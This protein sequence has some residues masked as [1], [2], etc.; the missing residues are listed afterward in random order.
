MTKR[1]KKAILLLGA[2]AAIA[3]PAAPAH[4]T[5]CAAADPTVDYVVCQTVYPTVAGAACRVKLLC[6]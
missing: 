3:A 5:T 2:V 4:A 6:Y 1:L